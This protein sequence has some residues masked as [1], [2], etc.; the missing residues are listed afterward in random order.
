LIRVW[1]AALLLLIVT[2]SPVALAAE[3]PDVEFEDVWIR[4]MPPFQKNSAA[5][6]TLINHG[7]V[8]IGIVGARSDVAK[9]MELH[10]TRMVDGLM[11]MEPLD[12]LAVAPGER[13]E[14]A[15][16]GAH[17]ML[18]DLEY[19]PVPGDDIEICLLLSSGDEV[20]AKADVRKTAPEKDSQE[21][22]HHHH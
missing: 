9:K 7:T 6:L 13:V 18:F 21:H 2:V 11:R 12:G 17:L 4:A 15:P 16:G 19:R 10:T 5:Y 1:K 20:C 14:L 8:A 22:Q 3:A